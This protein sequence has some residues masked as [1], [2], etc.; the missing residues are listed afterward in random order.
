MASAA[1]VGQCRVYGAVYTHAPILGALT[2]VAELG[3]PVMIL[4][5]HLISQHDSG[6]C[7][8]LVSWRRRKRRRSG[9]LDVWKAEGAI[10]PV[11]VACDS[12]ATQKQQLPYTHLGSLS[13]RSGG[14][15][16]L[17]D[18]SK[19]RSKGNENTSHFV[20]V[21]VARRS[22]NAHSIVAPKTAR[23]YF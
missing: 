9:G 6:D 19:G 1:A 2:L 23:F 4:L 17:H 11:R 7:K 15:S 13:A 20:M 22:C 5:L 10:T 3:S 8:G 14:H 16:P 21:G 12:T 18:P